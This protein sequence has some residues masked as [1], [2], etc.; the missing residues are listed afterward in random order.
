[1]HSQHATPAVRDFLTSYIPKALIVSSKGAP[2]QLLETIS[3]THYREL[4]VF[5]PQETADCNEVL[6]HTFKK[7]RILINHDYHNNTMMPEMVGKIIYGT[8]W[9][10]TDPEFQGKFLG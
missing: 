7:S 6:P 8:R 5:M 2:Y 1:M 3:L 9:P 4:T 10:H